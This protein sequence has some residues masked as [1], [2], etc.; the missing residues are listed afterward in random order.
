M[1]IMWEPVDKYIPLM[2]STTEMHQN[3]NES[4]M[5]IIFVNDHLKYL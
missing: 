4:K 1:N 5:N 3:L 2:Q